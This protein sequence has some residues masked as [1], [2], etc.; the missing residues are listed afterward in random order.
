MKKIFILA[1]IVVICGVFS[2]QSPLAQEETESVGIIK[3]TIKFL[4]DDDMKGRYP[5]ESENEKAADYIVDFFKHNGLSPVN[6][7]FKQEFPFTDSLKLG[8]NNDVFFEILIRKPGVPESMLRTRKKSW[9]TSEDW[10]PMRFTDNGEAKGKIAFCGYGVTAKEVGYDDYANI[11]V[12]GKIVVVLADSAE[13]MPL[14]D[15]WTPYSE[16]TY[17]ARNAKEHGAAAIVFV[18]VKHDSVNTFYKFDAV[19]DEEN[20]GIIAI[21]ASRTSIARFF[22]K[23]TP[24]LK[25]E[26]KIDEKKEPQSFILPDVK[27]SIKTDVQEVTAKM[28]NVAGFVEG[29]DSELKN[30]YIIIGA[31]FDALGAYWD[32]PKW[33]PNIWR[34]MNGANDNAS[35]TAAMLKIAKQI[36]RSPWKRSVLFIGFN[37]NKLGSLGS[38]YYVENP[39]A[40]LEKTTAMINLDMVGKMRDGKLF[41]LG[42]STGS[43]FRSIA[44]NAAGADS[45]LKFIE[46][47]DYIEPSDFLPF[48]KQNV[49]VMNLSTGSDKDWDSYND[50][51]D[52]INYEGVGRV[53]NFV[54]EFLTELD[55]YEQAPRFQPDPEVSDFQ[56]V[57][58]GYRCWLG[59]EPDY[60][61]YPEGL[62][63]WEVHR[64]SPAAKA[65][66]KPGDIITSFKGKKVESYRDLKSTL[67]F[68]KPG[69]VVETKILRDGE[70]KTL[71][72]EIEKKK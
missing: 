53:S 47:K 23:A 71:N 52:E 64:Y 8:K 43:N 58:K 16:L 20:P 59:I 2:I 29:T 40:P 30:E 36:A 14:D 32:K 33:R 61:I 42:V 10:M 4:A 21:Q 19:K 51:A 39:L 66:L 17:K 6:N 41:A 68:V 45:V 49:P 70:P 1:S 18:K 37:G 5:N 7:S 28:S 46:A 22:P 62:G 3:K 25:L 12:K 11:D 31:H 27:M 54:V 63:I 15:F 50:V 57:E 34:V 69:D 65:K 55:N 44:K 48:Y 67:R 9:K 35:G 38:K 13:G 24:L 72:I 26:K 56:R 60:T